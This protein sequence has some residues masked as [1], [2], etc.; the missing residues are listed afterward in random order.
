MIQFIIVIFLSFNT[1]KAELF[2][3]KCVLTYFIVVQYVFKYPFAVVLTALSFW[4]ECGVYLLID[5]WL[6]NVLK[7][8][9]EEKT[10]LILREI[11][12][13]K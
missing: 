11:S 9:T 6:F 2:S 10:G 12:S 7:D 5:L 8:S 13:K 4:C 3:C 1:K